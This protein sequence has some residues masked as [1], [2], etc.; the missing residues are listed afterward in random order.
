VRGVITAENPASR[1]ALLHNNGF[2]ASSIWQS[3]TPSKDSIKAAVDPL[4]PLSLFTLATSAEERTRLVSHV[5]T[6]GPRERTRPL[7]DARLRAALLQG[8]TGLD[9]L[10]V[11]Q[12]VAEP[13]FH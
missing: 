8:L 6:Q 12:A 13:G 11:L 10:R 3:V 7:N 9:R 2:W 5:L 1:S 4:E